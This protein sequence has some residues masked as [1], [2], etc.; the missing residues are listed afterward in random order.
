M[1]LHKNSERG[2]VG[3][4]MSC[5]MW[6]H[7][8]KRRGILTQK[9]GEGFC[10]LRFSPRHQ[11]SHLRNAATCSKLRGLEI[12]LFHLFFCLPHFLNPKFS[13]HVFLFWDFVCLKERYIL[14]KIDQ[15]KSIQAV[16]GLSERGRLQSTQKNETNIL[17]IFNIIYNLQ[18][19]V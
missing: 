15:I 12:V 5:G 4:S 1:P 14:E 7:K 11:P 16:P 8:L 18:C 3:Q 2:E 9:K 17:F 10:P 19:Y 13:N 6:I